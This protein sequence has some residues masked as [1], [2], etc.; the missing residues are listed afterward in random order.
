MQW[1]LVGGGIALRG[2]DGWTTLPI[3]VGVR[4]AS[5]VVIRGRHAPLPAARAR[6]GAQA[7]RLS[8]HELQNNGSPQRGVE[9]WRDK[10][11]HARREAGSTKVPMRDLISKRLPSE[12][13][14]F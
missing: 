2:I 8:T 11:R 4:A 6:H 14:D 12:T 10:S 1:R 7:K 5:L 9:N 3:A 13:D